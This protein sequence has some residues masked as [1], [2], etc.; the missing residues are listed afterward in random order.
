METSATSAGQTPTG[1]EH[2]HIE[3]IRQE[4]PAVLGTVYLNTGTCGPLPRRAI[5]AMQQAQ[6]EEVLRGRID[7]GHYPS[8]AAAMNGVKAA[9]ADVLGCDPT[10]LALSRHTTDG[11]NLA[12]AGYPWQPGDEIVTTNIEHPS[13]LLPM[14]LARRRG[15]VTVRVADIGLGE[16]TTERIVA[17]F[18][19]Q[20]T[21]RTRMLV[22][23]HISYTTGAVLPLKEIVAM[24]HSHDVLVLVDGAQ[25]YG[26][27]PLDLHDLAVDYYAVPGQKW[28]CG[29]EG[30]GAFYARAASM[31]RIEQTIVG[32]FGMEWDS[33]DYLGGS[34]MPAGDARRFDVGSANLPLLI[35][36]RAATEWI[37]DEV[38][39]PWAMARIAA[40]GTYAARTLAALDDVEVVTPEH[41]R[42]G[43]VSFV[44]GGIDPE[45]LMNRLYTEHNITVRYVT[46][47]INNPRASRLSVGFYNTE[48]DLDRLGEAIRVIRRSA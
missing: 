40:L 17:A 9:V 47:Y 27:I 2:A 21:L 3:R 29:P 12:L 20:I 18:E 19:Q 28:M 4:L 22:L 6:D 38:G 16:G 31:E 37:R 34:Y 45:D 48:D 25:S 36:Q 41:R 35:G 13:G 8:L 42:A 26:Q 39:L 46:R 10:E 15:G 43:L 23:S 1:D 30:T 14:F 11:M 44:V 33:L 7:P 24:A 5:S 32:P